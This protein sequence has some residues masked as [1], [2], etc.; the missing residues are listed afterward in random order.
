MIFL[1]LVIYFCVESFLCFYYSFL[2]R[3]IVKSIFSSKGT[4]YVIGHEDHNK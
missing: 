2:S 3:L 1:V 4:R